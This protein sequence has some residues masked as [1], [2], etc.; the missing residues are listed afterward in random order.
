MVLAIA[1][2]RGPTSLAHL[3]RE[4]F[5]LL[6]DT[7]VLLAGVRD[8]SPSEAAALV[9]SRA[10]ILPPDR[11]IGAGGEAVFMGALGRLAPRTRDVV[12]HLDVSV[13]EPGQFPVAAVAPSAGG[14]SLERLRTFVGELSTWNSDGTIRISGVSVT[15]VDAR[16]DPGGVRMHELAGFVMRLFRRR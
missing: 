3:A 11:L 12:L 16:K 13:L 8:A 5:P 4:R 6:Q 2:G 9:E 7:D 1:T 15:G 10:T 14:L